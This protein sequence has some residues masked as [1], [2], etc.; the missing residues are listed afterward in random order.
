MS[1]EPEQRDETLI[2]LERQVRAS[3]RDAVNRRSRKP[4]YWGGLKGYEQLQAIAQ[5]LNE[6]PDD[7][8]ETDYLRRLAMQVNRVVDKN[9]TQAQDLRE[10][11]CWLRRIAHCLRYP[12]DPE[13]PLPTSHQVKRDMEALLEDF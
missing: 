13:K 10:A 1:Q 7:G 2:A 5:V 8:P 9:R 11:H 6:V 4:F 3:I 12:A